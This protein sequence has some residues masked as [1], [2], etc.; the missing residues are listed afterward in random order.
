MSTDRKY[1]YAALCIGINNYDNN[2]HLTCAVNDAMAMADMFRELKYDVVTLIDEKATHSH[3][4]DAYTQLMSDNFINH[5]DAI[6]LYFAG[7]GFVA[8]QSDCLALK[9]CAE[10]K[11]GDGLP[12]KGK[13]IN[14]Q[15]FIDVFRKRT[16][17][18]LII[19]L[20]ACR[21][22]LSDYMDAEERGADFSKPEDLGK[23][24]QVPTQTFIAYSTSFNAGAKDGGGTDGHSKYT[25]ALLEEIRK[26]LPI[27]TIFKNVRAKVHQNEN[28]QLPWEYTCLTSDFYFNYGQ[29]DPYYDA[30]YSMDAFMYHDYTAQSDV[31]KKILYGLTQNTPFSIEATKELLLKYKKTLSENDLFVIGRKIYSA[32]VRSQYANELFLRI[33]TLRLPINETNH[34]LRGIYYEI[35]F[36]ENNNLRP[37]LLGSSN[38]LTIIDRLQSLLKDEDAAKFVKKYVEVNGGN[39]KYELW[40]MSSM[41][42]VAVE[43]KIMNCTDEH[44]NV[45]YGICKIIVD[46]ENVLTKLHEDAT[47][48][49]T[50]EQ[51]REQIAECLSI[52]MQ[53]IRIKGL[54]K[55]SKHETKYVLYYIDNIEEQLRET[56]N[57]NIP[58][59]V[60]VLSSNSYVDDLEDVILSEV[61]YDGSEVFAEGSCWVDVH[62]EFDGEDMGNCSFPCSFN[63]KLYYD[64]KHNEYMIDHG[65]FKVNTDSY[66][67]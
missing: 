16:T 40:D 42:N 8:N 63:V 53:R 67:K 55:D 22:D 31:A 20:D 1:K 45:I 28:D 62:I 38:I 60:S 65:A 26:E 61:V 23:C 24:V 36:D 64:D 50:N 48:I 52:P 57:K 25:A 56:I 11:F 66:Y 14:V 7:H 21:K 29:L 49:L 39:P 10:I 33:Q 2:K 19:I 43:A 15:D 4:V 6:I 13:S 3:Y 5:Y 46:D 41:V 54:E 27:E 59:E 35:Y 44:N 32:A 18:T 58:D 47:D 34:L 17:P 37:K 9:D 51:L 30:E 12:A